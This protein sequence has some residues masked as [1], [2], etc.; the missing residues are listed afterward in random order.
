MRRQ[1]AKAQ[2]VDAIIKVYVTGVGSMR[3]FLAI[4]LVL[5]L[6]LPCPAL[7]EE[8]GAVGGNTQ[9]RVTYNVTDLGIVEVLESWKN[10]KL[11]SGT[12]PYFSAS[13][14]SGIIPVHVE[15]GSFA[16]SFATRSYLKHEEG[17][18][19][20]VTPDFYYEDNALDVDVTLR[21][22]GNLSYV[23][24]NLEPLSVESNTLKWRLSDVQ[25]QVV[26]AEFIQTSAFA[27]PDYPVGSLYQV[28][29]ATLP[30]LTAEEIPQNP[31]EAL[32]ELETIIKMIGAQED[33]DPDMVRILRR[34]LS[35][36]YYLFAVYG[37]VKDFVPEGAELGEDGGGSES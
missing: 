26:I 35:K 17:K 19:Y 12:Y 31:D 13:R 32:K 21:F 23:S 25:H 9:V 6:V 34:S 1:D 22:P 28:D 30:E 36:F 29:P 11:S 24:S 2:R 3:C 16:V 18:V 27:P 7:A 10:M 15:N 14:E 4:S 37:L 8:E 20:F 33:V 5:V